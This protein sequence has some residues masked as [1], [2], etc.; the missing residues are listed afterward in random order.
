MSVTDVCQVCESAPGRHTCPQCGA[1]VCDDHFDRASGL[2]VQ[3]VSAVRSE[4][5]DCSD[6]LR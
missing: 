3:C 6:V 5:D 1:L 2:C 4:P